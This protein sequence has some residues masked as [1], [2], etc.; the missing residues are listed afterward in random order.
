MKAIEVTGTIDEHGQLALDR[1]LP[2]S[3]RRVRAIV[4]VEEEGDR[5][6]ASDW[7]QLATEQFFNGYS[8]ADS[9]YD[10]V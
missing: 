9:I 6:E 3:Q 5:S 8:E 4:L 10:R 1:P 2:L 7:S